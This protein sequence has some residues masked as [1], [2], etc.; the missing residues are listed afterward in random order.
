LTLTVQHTGGWNTKTSGW[1]PL[2][3]A[4]LYNPLS[5]PEKE[6]RK[7]VFRFAVQRVS[8]QNHGASS[9]ARGR[10]GSLVVQVDRRRTPTLCV[11]AEV[12]RGRLFSVGLPV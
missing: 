3:M 6:L 12:A 5:E 8:V 11:K 7:Y 10:A 2:L 1:V 4:R 9:R